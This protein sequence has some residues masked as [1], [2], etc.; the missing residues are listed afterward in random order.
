M[1]SLLRSCRHVQRGS[2]LLLLSQLTMSD[3]LIAAT[4]VGIIFGYTAMGG[5][6]S[7]IWI[8]VNP[9]GRYDDGKADCVLA[10]FGW[11]IS[12]VCLT[13]LAGHHIGIA[14]VRLCKAFLLLPE[15]PS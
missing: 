1:V 15:K 14:A 12:L 3:Q 7:G 9:P 2:D 6:I 5:L 8:A 13:A 11:P 10:G 4:V